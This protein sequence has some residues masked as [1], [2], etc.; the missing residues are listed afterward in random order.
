[1]DFHQLGNGVHATCDADGGGEKAADQFGDVGYALT[2]VRTQPGFVCQVDGAPKSSCERTPPATAYWSLWWSDGKSDTWKYASVGVGSLHVKDGGYV[3][4]SWQKGTA[5]APPRVSLPSAASSAPT[6]HPTS[7]P[8][9]H[10]SGAPSSSPPTSTTPSAPTSSPATKP[11]TK[12]TTKPGKHGRHQQGATP[13]KQAKPRDHQSQDRAAAALAG[14]SSGDDGGSGSG[15][16]PGWV[17][18]VAVAVLFA[19][20]GAFAL[21]RRKSRG[22]A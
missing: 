21:V 2:P 19:A 8:T 20:G 1:V 3:A 16:L 14:V 4:L 6:T 15:G 12:P 17:A 10:P 22:S 18:P 11:T 5:Q 7:Q 9:S 13:S